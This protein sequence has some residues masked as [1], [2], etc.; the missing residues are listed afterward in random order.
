M[1]Y[2][3]EEGSDLSITHQ[4][5]LALRYRNL[6]ALALVRLMNRLA[7]KSLKCEYLDLRAKLLHHSVLLLNYLPREEVQHKHSLS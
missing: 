1:I 4:N 7:S 5:S 3:L 2:S 6:G